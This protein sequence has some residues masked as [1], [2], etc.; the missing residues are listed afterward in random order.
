MVVCDPGL[1][2]SCCLVERWRSQMRR[3]RRSLPPVPVTRVPPSAS[4]LPR[5]SR[6]RTATAHTGLRATDS[7][8][9]VIRTPSMAGWI[10]INGMG[11]SAS[12]ATG[13]VALAAVDTFDAHAIRAR[14][15][16]AP[17]A[18]ATDRVPPSRWT[19]HAIRAAIPDLVGDDL[20]GVWRVLHRLGIIRRS[21]RVQQFSPDPEYAAKLAHVEA[22]LREAATTPT[23]IQ[24]LFMDQMGLTRWPEPGPVWAEAA[25][26]PVPQ[27]DR[28]QTKQQQWRIVGAL[29]AV[30]GQVD[31]LDGYIVGRRQLITFYQQ[32]ER[33]YPDAERVYVIQDNWSIHRHDDVVAA[34][35]ELPRITP[36]FLPTYA[37]WL[38]PIEKL[39]RFLRQTLLR[40]HPLAADWDALK[41]RVA[42]ALEQ[43]ATGGTPHTARLLRY[44]GLHG[45]GRLAQALHPP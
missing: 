35:A 15:Q 1:V 32:L 21:T 5:C 19:L 3:A 17:P 23:R 14:L 37:P 22:C 24:T 29:N 45:N 27:T 2:R 13:T 40:N 8:D 36:I 42:D 11:W 31:T 41:Q 25:P 10:A 33:A 16:Q 12:S 43:F 20:S 38:N 6:S 18:Q 7:S 34:L 44:V 30:T 9:H 26:A 39:W 28:A 4:G